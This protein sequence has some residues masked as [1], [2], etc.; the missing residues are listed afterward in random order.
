LYADCIPRVRPRLP[1]PSSGLIDTSVPI[2]T[3]PANTSS[4]TYL[5]LTPLLLEP[6]LLA[7]H[8]EHSLA[9]RSSVTLPEIAGEPFADVA[10]GWGTRMSIERALAMSGLT[11]TVTYEV[12]DLPGVLDFVTHQLAVALMP[13]AFV[14]SQRAIAL[15][16]VAD[17]M[18]VL[19][20]S[21][22]LP[23]QRRIGAAA[24][25]LSETIVALAATL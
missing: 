21:L 17:P 23:S 15:V 10:V 25:A 19:E 7:C 16:P 11:R 14:G 8:R 13:A 12:N 6:I 9:Q 3:S 4:A 1:A 22:A 18:L 24:A 5:L 20:T 2:A